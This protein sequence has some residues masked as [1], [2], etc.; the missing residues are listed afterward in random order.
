[1]GLRAAS[2]ERPPG[3]RQ[4]WRSGPLSRRP[5]GPFPGDRRSRRQVPCRCWR[6]RVETE[7]IRRPYVT[8]RRG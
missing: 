1:M 2:H 8:A 3:A 5:A 6:A 4:A 7:V